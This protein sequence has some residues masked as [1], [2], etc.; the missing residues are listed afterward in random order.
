MRTNCSLEQDACEHVD[1]PRLPEGHHL[2]GEEL[3]HQPVPEEVRGDGRH[4]AHHGDDDEGTDTDEYSEYQS[5]QHVRL[6]SSVFD[7]S[8]RASLGTSSAVSQRPDTSGG[9]PFLLGLRRK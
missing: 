1:A 6:S 7:Y 2:D 5:L 3:G 8:E 9:F 4:Q